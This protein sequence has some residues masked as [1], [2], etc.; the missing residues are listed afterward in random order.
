MNLKFLFPLLGLILGI[1][2]SSEYLKAS[3]IGGIFIGTAVIIWTI[4]TILSKNPLKGQKFS[5][6]HILWITFL[7]AGV[8]SLDFEYR[9]R[10][11]IE[12]EL[13]DERIQCTGTI[14]KVD[15]VTDG[16]RFTVKIKSLKDSL[17]NLKFSNLYFLV[18][19]N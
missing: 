10:P 15:Y 11:Y 17:K 14:E 12:K 9:S 2:L 4:I 6:L 3:W 7:F 18:K 1:F 16:D 13:K 5:Y 8:G 19:T